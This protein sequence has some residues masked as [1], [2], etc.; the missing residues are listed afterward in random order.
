ML[1]TAIP[2]SQ[3]LKQARNIIKRVAQGMLEDPE[4]VPEIILPLKLQG[5]ADITD[6]AIVCRLKITAKPARASWVQREALKR[7]YAAL[8]ADGI[9]FASGAVTVKS[10]DPDRLVPSP[11]AGAPATVPVR[12]TRLAGITG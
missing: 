8:E 10:P 6:G 7:V 1:M 5:I 11:A 3:D 12:A 9:A 4:L 2:A